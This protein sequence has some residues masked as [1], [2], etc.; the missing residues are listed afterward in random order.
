M[1][2]TS[3]TKRIKANEARMTAENQVYKSL[4]NEICRGNRASVVNHLVSVF[5]EKMR[6]YFFA[7]E[8]TVNTDFAIEVLPPAAAPPA[9]SYIVLKHGPTKTVVWMYGPNGAHDST[10]YCYHARTGHVQHRTYSF[11]EDDTLKRLL[12]TPMQETDAAA[13]AN[14]PN[15]ALLHKDILF[16]LTSF[17]TNRDLMACTLVCKNWRKVTISDN[18]WHHR[19]PLHTPNKPC[20]RQFIKSNALL[21]S[22]EGSE[23]EA[24]LL[25]DMQFARIVLK[26][27]TNAWCRKY[28]LFLKEHHIEYQTTVYPLAAAATSSR[29]PREPVQKKQKLAALQRVAEARAVLSDQRSNMH[30]VNTVRSFIDQTQAEHIV[31]KSN[32]KHTHVHAFICGA[33]EHRTQIGAVVWITSDAKLRIANPMTSKGY[34]VGNVKQVLHEMM[35][36]PMTPGP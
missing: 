30:R 9:Q 11:W 28:D 15:W 23:L 25:K 20:F 21:H 5:Q 3:L 18:V 19:I 34:E 2:L 1:R 36:L 24:T 12:V 26:N 27:I 13:A 7:A 14:I 35:F 31:W 16:Y 4:I 17:L 22:V 10:M 8:E 32:A 33:L 29:P 6:S